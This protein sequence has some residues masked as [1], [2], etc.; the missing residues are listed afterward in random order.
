MKKVYSSIRGM[1]DFD[2]VKSLAFGEI[3]ER[4]KNIL[5]VF[6]YKEI[7][8]P[9][10]EEKDLFIKGVGETTDIV[11]QQMF[12]IEGKDIVLR[13]EG[14]AQ[15]IRYYLQ[16]SLHKISNFHKFF[17][18][19]PMFR[20]ERPQKGR[21]R[22]FHHIGAEAIGSN[23]YYLDAE[24]IVLALKILDQVGVSK[25]ELK[26]NTLGCNQD[27][28]KFSQYLKEK[29]S[30]Q[31]DKLCDDCQRRLDKNPLRVLDCKKEQCRKEVIALNLEQEHICSACRNKFKSLLDLLGD[32]GIKYVYSPYMVRGLDYYTDT[33]FE[34]SSEGL[35]SQDAI[36]A[37]GRY[38]N[39]IKY[40]GGP[41]IPAIG[42]ALGL[43]RVLLAL[44]EKK[45]EEKLD[46]FVAITNQELFTLGANILQQL[47][48]EGLSSDLDY[49]G[50]SLKGQ[51]RS[52]QKKGSRIVVILG[53]DEVAEN[54]VLI[55]D[56]NKS[57]QKKVKKENLIF[58]IKQLIK[59]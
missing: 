32:L 35:G 10:L 27:K 42:F 28:I 17:Y 23:S 36:G 14:T 15:V 25:K 39:L 31:K 59:V 13:P 1:F 58:E 50:K 53:E 9:I 57:I 45:K 56:M 47:R 4:A 33:V 6:N 18:T 11:E 54:A 5:K 12:K 43:E 26:I 37:G 16:N 40:L 48:D 20:G 7:I 44:G 3:V 8:L 30:S 19:G 55:K 49:C 46:V 2:P 38:N 41:D 52:A 29:L 24:M 22:Q 34:I 51:M 21:L